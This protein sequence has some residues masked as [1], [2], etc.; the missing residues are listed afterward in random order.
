MNTMKEGKNLMRNDFLI[1]R[2]FRYVL[3]RGFFDWLP[4]KPYLTLK[5]WACMGKKL[6]LDNPV[7]FNE[8]L[9]WLKL[10]D[11]KLEYTRMVD[12]YEVKGYVS[13][14]IGEEYIIPTL[15]VWDDFDEIDFSKL[16]NQFVLKCTHDSGGI[17]ICRDKAALDKSAAKKKLS[18][19]L[20]RNYYKSGREWPYKDVKPRIIAE[21][22]MEDESGVELKDYKIFCFDGFAKAMFIASDQQ[23]QDEE[24]KFDFFDMDF[25]HLPFTNGHPNA[26]HEIKRPESLEE[27][28]RLAEK[29]S[30]GIPQVRVDFYD[31]NGKVYFGEL[32]LSHWSG[33]TPFEPEEWDAKFGEW[34]KIPENSGGGYLIAGKGWI[35]YYHVKNV[36]FEGLTDYKFYCFKGEPQ[37]LYVSKGMENH[38]TAAVSFLT[39]DWQFAPFG[40][41]DYKPLEY[42]PQKPSRF[43]EMVAVARSLS[44]GTHFLRVDLY[45]ISGRV[46]FSELTFS[47][48]SGM[49]PFQPEEYDKKLGEMLIL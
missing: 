21:A 25:Q 48:C 29:L 12:K 47:P 13:E 2:A 3:A 41:S 32:T 6:N 42:M 49:M 16:P 43:N 19:S 15:G 38:A 4:D 23:V 33:M 39:V 31:V 20:K 9:Q 27:M 45:E 17:V 36:S 8:K 11:R 18:A 24:T 40:R 28:R 7:T 10:Y 22:Y 37:Y 26:K 46:Y 35:L 44:S 5:Y 30:E 14:K 1:R 34:I